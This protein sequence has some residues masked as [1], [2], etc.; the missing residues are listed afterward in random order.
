MTFVP[1]GR[2]NEFSLVV[3]GSSSNGPVGCV[4]TLEPCRAIYRRAFV[5]GVPNM[6]AACRP[7]FRKGTALLAYRLTDA[8]PD[9]SILAIHRPTASGC[10]GPP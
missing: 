2:P 5:I 4:T 3:P 9:L 7:L 6:A 8:T 10:N 1:D